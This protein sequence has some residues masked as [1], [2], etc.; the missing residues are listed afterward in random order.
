MHPKPCRNSG[1]PPYSFDLK[2]HISVRTALKSQEEQSLTHILTNSAELPWVQILNSLVFFQSNKNIYR[3]KHLFEKGIRKKEIKNTEWFTYAKN[4]LLW[5]PLLACRR[6]LCSKFPGY[7]LASR[8]QKLNN[9]H[10]LVQNSLRFFYLPDWPKY[11]LYTESDMEIF[12]QY[13]IS[14]TLC[15]HPILLVWICTTL[16]RNLWVCLLHS[17]YEIQAW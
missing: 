16:L 1:I 17:S 12:T 11:L 3:G 9:F 13:L 5:E 8:A 7:Q 2:W 10:L 15:L 14:I 4:S 6:S